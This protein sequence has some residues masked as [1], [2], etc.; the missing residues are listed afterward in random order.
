MQRG[1]GVVY[2]TRE[3]NIKYFLNLYLLPY[4]YNIKSD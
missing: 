1:Q 3:V 4:F 2:D